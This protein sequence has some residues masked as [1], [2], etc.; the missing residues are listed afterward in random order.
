MMRHTR[1]RIAFFGIGAVVCFA[2]EFL[3]QGSFC[4]RQNRRESFEHHIADVCVRAAQGRSGW[5]V[6]D[7][8]GVS[9]AGGAGGV[10][11]NNTP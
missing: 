8:A 1:A 6:N 10:V 3:H 4:R 2:A 7:G 11:G 9:G 5:G